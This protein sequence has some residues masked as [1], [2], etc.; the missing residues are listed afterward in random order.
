MPVLTEKQIYKIV[1]ARHPNVS[2]NS[3]RKLLKVV[4][5]ILEEPRRLDMSDWG[6]KY[7]KQALKLATTPLTEDPEQEFLEEREMP[8]CGTVACL[9]GW[10][11]VTLMPR[12]RLKDLL[13]AE[14]KG[15]DPKKA[16]LVF[17]GRTP[18]LAAELLGLEGGAIYWRLF[19]PDG[20][21]G[22]FENAYDTAR[23]ALQRAKATRDR[24]IHFIY[25]AE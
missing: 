17:P 11:L 6:T 8:A 12:K 2:V 10:T 3:A 19:Y 14:N 25:H 7:S 4:N 20:W 23:T 5:T 22:Q 13:A 15:R 1:A 18:D 16:P 21:P 24:V 9:A